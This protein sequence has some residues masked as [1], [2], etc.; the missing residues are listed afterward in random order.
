MTW[1]TWAA[2]CSLGA[3]ITAAPP[4]SAFDRGDGSAS[5]TVKTDPTSDLVDLYTWMEPTTGNRVYL[6]MTVFP[7]ASTTERF[8]TKYAYVF[9]TN[10]R[11]V[12]NDAA[13][14][15][16]VNIICKFDSTM[17]TQNFE[18]W[19]GANE[20]VKGKVTANGQS[21]KS[22]AMTVFAGPRNDPFFLNDTALT[23]AM[24]SIQTSYGAITTK[25]AAKCANFSTAQ[26]TSA[27]TALAPTGSA[28]A[29]KGKNVLAIVVSIDPS[30]LLPGSKKVLSV[31]ASTNQLA[32]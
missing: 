23:A 3:A 15:A 24:S 21:S 31:W 16:E 9:H 8:S 27:R 2:A 18:C 19:A 14:D 5:S 12:W 6:V 13:P 26:N 30:I 7:G 17:P 32:Q 20:Y 1:K 22:G 4:A 25:D 29:F 11:Q 10:A 28:D